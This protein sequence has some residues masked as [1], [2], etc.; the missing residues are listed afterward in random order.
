MNFGLSIDRQLL[1]IRKKIWRPKS[2][3][4]AFELIRK[5]AEHGFVLVRLFYALYFFIL[6]LHFVKQWSKLISAVV[7]RLPWPVFWIR[8]LDSP[9]V[10]IKGF[11]IFNVLTVGLAMLYPARRSLRAGAFLGTLFIGAIYSADIGGWPRMTCTQA[12]TMVTFILIFL[13][14]GE[15]LKRISD[16]WRATCVLVLLS[17][18]VMLSYASSGLW[19]LKVSIWSLLE[20]NKPMLAWDGLATVISGWF[21]TSDR[22][23]AMGPFLIENRWASGP[24]MILATALEI[25]S[26]YFI[27]RPGLYRTWGILFMLFHL[28]VI[29]AME[30]PFDENHLL[31]ALFLV[32]SPFGGED[33][34]T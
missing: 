6:T 21:F 24:G 11:F 1:K 26:F 33:I 25:S 9:P 3:P 29:L 16:S 28:A 32:C 34:K 4:R 18:T 14:D 13:P 23:G 15:K 12:Y 31:V 22:I 10:W 8:Y 19:R 5:Q 30:L 17:M 20:G 2:T 7:P 27:W